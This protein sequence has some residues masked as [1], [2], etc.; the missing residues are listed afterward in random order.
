MLLAVDP[1]HDDRVLQEHPP[2]GGAEL[3][4]RDVV[5]GALFLGELPESVGGLAVDTEGF[6]QGVDH[7][8]L[9]AV[10]AT[11]GPR[12]GDQGFQD[13]FFVGLH[14]VSSASENIR[15]A[16][17]SE[18][19]REGAEEAP[20]CHGCGMGFSLRFAPATVALLALLAVGC[21]DDGRDGPTPDAGVD[22]EAVATPMRVVTW[23][24]ENLFDEVDDPDT[25]DDVPSA[26]VVNRKL[27]DIAA[28][29]TPLEADFIALQEVENEAILGRLADQLGYEQ[30]GLI[31]AFDGRGID[32]GY[33]TR[34]PL[35]SSP[36]V[37]SHLGERFPLPDGSDDIYFTRDALEVFVD[38]GGA[39]VGVI[40][41]HFRSM[42]DGGADIRQAEAAYTAQIAEA[43]I[44][45]GLNNILVV[46]DLNDIPGSAPLD[47]ILAGSL[48]DLTLEVPEDDR[49]TF[50][51][52]RVRRQFD[53]IL[54]SPQMAAS[55]T[56][57]VILHGGEVDAAS[58]HQP[59]AA[60]FLVTP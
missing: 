38:V 17:R 44:S 32:V 22:A 18:A 24:V 26:A 12:H 43:R 4:E 59:V 28:V 3:G 40:I 33:I 53:Y 7:L 11:V 27:D 35:A 49:W 25:I 47:E 9:V 46:G 10:H 56:D 6:Q 8:G 34:L 1:G 14:R 23:N 15:A 19:R 16:V 13:G 31:D 42:R 41:V 36:M 55:A 45:S 48:V 58:D 20:V 29:L 51:F 37:T 21:G 52:D 30:Y 5:D 39:T 54:G 60:D 57:V 50:V 2:I